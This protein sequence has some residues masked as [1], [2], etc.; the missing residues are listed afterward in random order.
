MC[1]D[2]GIERSYFSRSWRTIDEWRL[3][4]FQ[5][6]E[7]ITMDMTQEASQR[8]RPV[9]VLPEVINLAMCECCILIDELL[10]ILRI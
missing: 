2:K 7:M 3:E 10:H 8:W 9:K 1:K 4:R 5:P 6:L